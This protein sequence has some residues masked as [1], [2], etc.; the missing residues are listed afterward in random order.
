MK[1]TI[2][3][4]GNMARGIGTRVLAGG[5]DLELVARNRA[6]AQALADELGG[7]TVGDQRQR[8]R[9]GARHPVRRRSRRRRGARRRAAAARSSSTSRTRVDWSTFDG[10]VTPADSSAAEEIAKLLPDGTPV[11]KAFNTTFAAT[12]SSGRGRGRA[13]R[14][15][16]RRRRRR[17]E[18]EGRLVRRGGRPAAARRRSAPARPPARAARV[19][20]HHRAGAAGRGLRQRD[21]APLVEALPPPELLLDAR[22]DLGEGPI[23]HPAAGR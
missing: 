22:A 15:P 9:R 11:V 19:P 18:G 16:A 8:R 3:G 10:L 5:N 1:V 14:R 7:G 13:A 6:A 23:W 12:L 17:R 4:A 21:Q 20:P 2:I